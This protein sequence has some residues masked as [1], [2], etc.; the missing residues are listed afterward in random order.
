MIPFTVNLQTGRPNVRIEIIATVKMSTV[1][2]ES[3]SPNMIFMYN[4][5]WLGKCG[6][7]FT[8]RKTANMYLNISGFLFA[9]PSSQT[10][11]DS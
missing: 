7:F 4:K 6:I 3:I 1:K 9:W 5:R 11:S 10:L 8:K 2:F